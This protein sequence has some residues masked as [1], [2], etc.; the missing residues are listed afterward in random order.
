MVLVV[1]EQ[2]IIM[3]NKLEQKK[4]CHH[5]LETERGAIDSQIDSYK[6]KLSNANVNYLEQLKKD[7]EAN[8]ILC[9]V[10]YDEIGQLETCL[11]ILKDEIYALKNKN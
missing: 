8:D 5:K 6:G 10:L 3:K 1:G 11:S 2:L 4:T 7:Q 9:E